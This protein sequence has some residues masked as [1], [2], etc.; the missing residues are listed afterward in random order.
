MW[1]TYHPRV[2]VNQDYLFEVAEATFIP[3]ERPALFLW[4]NPSIEAP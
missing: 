4:S 1:A 3:G 2:V